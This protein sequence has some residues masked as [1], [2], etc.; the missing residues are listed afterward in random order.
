MIALPRKKEKPTP[1]TVK[2]MLVDQLELPR[3]ITDNLC[4]MEMLGNRQ[5]IV[6]GSC[7]ILDY[8]DKKIRLN[9]GKGT[10]CFEGSQL[11]IKSL[12]CEQAVITGLISLVEFG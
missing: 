12:D 2:D 9:T 3:T 8:D 6:D 7:G 11:Q 1:K 10:V 4:Y 5:V